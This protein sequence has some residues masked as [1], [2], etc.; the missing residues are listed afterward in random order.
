MNHADELLKDHLEQIK[1]EKFC[2]YWNK[3]TFWIVTDRHNNVIYNILRKPLFDGVPQEYYEKITGR[4]EFAPYL[5]NYKW[6]KFK[7]IKS[8]DDL[9]IAML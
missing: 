9:F 2:P 8:I 5:D 6:V 7:M 1:K 4:W 3:Y